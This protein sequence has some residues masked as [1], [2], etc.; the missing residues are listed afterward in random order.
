MKYFK[1]S[2]V[3]L[4]VCSSM[5]M[6]VSAENTN[7]FDASQ[8][9]KDTQATLYQEINKSQLAKQITKSGMKSHFD[10][11]LN[12][13]TFIW[14]SHSQ[15]MP[16]FQGVAPEQRDEF[17]AAFY[18]GNLTGVS[19]KNSFKNKAVLNNITRQKSG[20]VVA[21]YTQE[22]YGVE[23]FNR[24]FNIIMTAD[25]EFVAASGFLAGNHSVESINAVVNFGTPE[26]ALRNAFT[27]MGGDEKNF[28][29]TPDS[30]SKN[31]YQNF[32]TA[33]KGN[34][35]QVLNQPRAKKVL[36]ELN[37]KLIAAHYVE[38]E[39]GKADELSSDYFAY[40]I[41]ADSGRVLYKKNLVN[42]EKAFNY[43]VYADTT[44]DNIPLDG[45]FGDVSP[46]PLAKAED[47]DQPTKIVEAALVSL[48]A[49]PI[50]TNDP[51][52]A[53]DATITSGNN[54][55][56][57][58]DVV[59]PQGFSNGD[60]HA[61][62]TSDFTFDY[63]L[64]SEQNHYSVA[65]RKAAITNLFYVTNYLHDQFYDHGFDEKSGNAQLVN[66]DRG[67]AEGDPLNV[68]AQDSSGFNNANM[69]T[70]ADGASPR[71]QMYLYDDFIAEVGEDYGVSIT[72]NPNTLL[73]S[74]RISQFG[75][76]RFSDLVN[77]EVVRVIDDSGDIYDG[78]QEPTNGADLKGKIAII[79]RGACNFT[80]KV[81]HAQEAGAI[82]AL[83]ANVP[84]RDPDG[85]TPAPMG[86]SDDTVIIP[87]MG[88]SSTDGKAI[89][90]AIEVGTTK[91]SMFNDTPYR[92]GTFDNGTIA[93]EWGHYI[94]NRLV[95][96][97]RG[98][99]NNQGR[100]MGEGWGDF[101]SLLLMVREADAQIEGNDKFQAAYSGTGYTDNFYTGIRRA[102]YSTNMAIH[103]LTFK[104]IQRGIALPEGVET[105]PNNAQVHASGE[106]WALMLWEA[107]VALINDERHTF[108]EA[109]SLMMEYLV[110]GYKMTPIAPTYTEARDAIL[111]VAY[112]KD[113]ADYKV[114][115]GA[116]AKRGLGLGAISPSRYDDTHAGVVESFK[117]DLATYS[118]VDTEINANYNSGTLGYCSNDD[119]LDIG[120]T[121]TV[122]VK[123]V[124]LGNKV[125]NNV[126]VKLE[127]ESKQTVSFVN[128]GEYVFDTLAPYSTATSAPIEITLNEAGIA[129][130]LRFK[131]TFPELEKDDD[132]VE[133]LDKTITT[134]VNYD[135]E[136][137]APTANSDFDNA[138]T[139]ASYANWVENVQD[140]GEAAERTF[141]LDKSSAAYFTRNGIDTGTQI[142]AL[143]NN[144]FKSDVAIET[145]EFEIGYNG[146]FKVS[147]WH[148]FDLE[149]EWDGGVV[150]IS[151][152]GGDWADVTKMGGTFATGYTKSLKK[153]EDQVL[154]ERKAFTGEKY[155][156]ESINFG[157]A[158][159]GN[160]V[161]F[162]FRL[163]TDAFTSAD[164]W[165]ID[166]IRFNNIESDI[167]HNVIA[168][169][170]YACNNRAP[171]ITEITGESIAERAY[172]GG[173]LNTGELTVSATDI[174]KNELTYAWSQVSGPEATLTDATSTTA[175]YTAP[176]LSEDT[177]LVFE[178]AIS[179]GTTVVK[180]EV[181][182]TVTN[183]ADEAPVIPQPRK[184]SSSM[185]FVALL[186][187]P[188]VWL[189]RK[190]YSK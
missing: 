34:T 166:N 85:I 161:R 91:V 181:T 153:N 184:S 109:Q 158:L 97:S 44:L 71:M 141:Y 13:P 103:P 160:K 89:Y 110:A 155:G 120:E 92:D 175:T 27:T 25:R 185:G 24:E 68:E 64:K 98:L 10:D 15:T 49:G 111:S 94:S 53:D 172:A 116:F 42:S 40:V 139:V 58:A 113:V 173:A 130:E 54:V 170:I 115:L 4:L 69:L 118:L 17:A 140:G 5:S 177:D 67:G 48:V 117:T 107:Y 144:N 57:Y 6:M 169:N 122:T 77:G 143:T 51:W 150:E 38:I 119:V 14:A 12:R 63:P 101:H 55:N 138:E 87:N 75:P 37:G 137:R 142:L 28:N 96:N 72:G 52:L 99:I 26:Q 136:L 82:G 176:Q 146:D 11:S 81:K 174:D 151:V 129:D 183:V 128:N 148:Y 100:S 104:H 165:Y 45:P 182:V 123:I 65:N 112:A 149:N 70:P 164:G 134:T 78:C 171:T 132:I 84:S 189:R 83:I 162:R 35:Y 133:A 8:V 145:R 80:V 125:L 124:N 167:F 147:W 9:T 41:A 18:L 105:V 30:H 154:S 29:V 47:K 126:K 90:D 60:Y 152:N 46:W 187:T 186:L 188:L 21:K 16:S 88:L 23:V 178:V 114:M 61:E 31:D 33:A 7:F 1:P 121:G 3:S 135:F 157:S 163:G 108:K 95:G 50:S 74:T 76:K 73:Q 32:S 2:I 20:S 19:P 36:Y 56:A 22:V 93:H 62:T 102:P 66:Y 106:I 179:D 59:A 43:R 190:R 131:V 156:N 168:G 127:L 39:A 86:G 79:D 159:N 180:Q